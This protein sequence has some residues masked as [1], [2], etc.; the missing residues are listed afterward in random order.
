MSRFVQSVKVFVNRSEA[1]EALGK[2]RVVRPDAYIVNMGR[3]CPTSS[4]KSA[5]FE[6]NAL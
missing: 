5:Y 6:C 4:E 3:W 1:E 2:A